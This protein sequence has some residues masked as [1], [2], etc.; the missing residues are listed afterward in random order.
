MVIDTVMEEEKLNVYRRIRDEI[1]NYVLTLP[2][3]LLPEETAQ[4]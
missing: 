4:T 3:V 1:R 2:E